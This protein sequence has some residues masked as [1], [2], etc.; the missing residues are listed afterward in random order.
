MKSEST[1]LTS[2]SESVRGLM[3]VA[4][5]RI[6]GQD[7]QLEDTLAACDTSSTQT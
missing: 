1:N 5:V 4:R 6:F 3:Q 7:E 2:N